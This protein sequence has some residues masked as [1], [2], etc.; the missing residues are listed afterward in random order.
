MPLRP[1]SLVIAG[2]GLAGLTA[3][4]AAVGRAGRITLVDSRPDPRSK[5]A[6]HIDGRSELLGPRSMAVI[7]ALGIGEAVR[8]AGVMIGGERRHENGGG[9]ADTLYTRGRL[10]AIDGERLRGIF[11]AALAEESSVDLR[12]ERTVINANPHAGQ[13]VVARAGSITEGVIEVAADLLVGADGADSSIRDALLRSGGSISRDELPISTYTIALRV[14][15]ATHAIAGDLLHRW[16]SGGAAIIALPDGSGLLSGVIAVRRGLIGEND[17]PALW[18]TQTFPSAAAHLTISPA[19]VFATAAAPVIETRVGRLIGGAT[20]LI[21]DAAGAAAPFGATGPAMAI[22]SATALVAAMDGDGEATDCLAAYES[23]VR[24][25][26]VAAATLGAF[27]TER[28]IAGSRP[29][30]LAALRPGRRL[31]LET[32]HLAHPSFAAVGGDLFIR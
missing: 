28:L 31:P 26:Y 7:D 21:G 24:A 3:A 11:V 30:P 8:T 5:G 1:R 4:R 2:A 15:G 23:A 17:D 27:A 20:A 9:F 6:H 19:A 18:L 14:P 25:E 32:I 12:F 13:I 22:A 10:L 29:D 16:T